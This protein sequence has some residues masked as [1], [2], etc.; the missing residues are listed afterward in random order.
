MEAQTQPMW[1][2]VVAAQQ[3]PQ[4]FLGQHR[5]ARPHWL[6]LFANVFVGMANV[7]FYN[8]MVLTPKYICVS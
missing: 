1:Q 6:T 8:K 3:A 2:M 4:Q 5:Y 7:I